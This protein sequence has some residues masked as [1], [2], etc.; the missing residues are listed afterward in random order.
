ME[1]K[2]N[3]PSPNEAPLEA[4][5]SMGRRGAAQRPQKG[6]E[7]G[8]AGQD[9]TQREK[10]F[11]RYC[12]QTGNLREAAARAG[13]EKD[14]EA[15]ALELLEKPPVRAWL[16]RL[17]RQKEREEK[18]R[19]DRAA[20]GLERIAYGS[21]ADAVRLLQRDEPP[22]CRELE[23][24]DL[25]CISEIKYAR[26]GTIDLKFYNRME[27][28]ERLHRLCAPSGGTEESFYTALE[29][30]ARLLKQAGWPQEEG[31]P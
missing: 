5:G 17:R 13:Y 28:L 24:M 27:A 20:A 21:I 18:K 1:Q 7:G 6:N 30:S 19:R 25:Y 26:N 3:A 31:G 15:A 8:K 29:K 14:P 22:T 10:K 16:E 4:G 23:Q 11:C 9:V 2:Q 12:L